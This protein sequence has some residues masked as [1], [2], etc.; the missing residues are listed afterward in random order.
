[1]DFTDDMFLETVNA[2]ADLIK[3]RQDVRAAKDGEVMVAATIES[4]V[5]VVQEAGEGK[6]QIT[7]ERSYPPPFAMKQKKD[8]T[9]S[10]PAGIQLF[11]TVNDVT[12]VEGQT[13]RLPDGKFQIL[14]KCNYFEEA[15]KWLSARYQQAWSQEYPRNHPL[16]ESMN[17]IR[18]YIDKD[19]ILTSHKWRTVSVGD[20]YKF[21]VSGKEEK[22]KEETNLFR[23]MVPGRKNVPYIQPGATVRFYKV[24]AE[25]WIALREENNNNSSATTDAEASAVADGDTH[26]K[27]NLGKSVVEYFALACKGGSVA[28]EDYDPLLEYTE[29]LHVSKN[30]DAHNLIPVRQFEQNQSAM[31][32]TAYFYVDRQYITKWSPDTVHENRPGVAVVRELTDVKDFLH[33]YQGQKSV[34]CSLRF[35]VFQWNGKPN[36]NERYIVKVMCKKESPMWRKFGITNMDAYAYIMAANPQ[37]PLHVTAN[38]WPSAVLSHESNKPEVMNDK[39]ELENIRG[40]YVYM[41]SDVTPDYLRYFKQNG[42]RLSLDYVKREFADWE[43]TNKRTGVVTITLKPLDP[44]KANPL[45]ERGIT[46]NVLALGNGFQTE[47][48]AAADGTVGINHAYDGP[49][50]ELFK[51]DH[52]FYFLQSKPVTKDE[53]EAAKAASTDGTMD[54][55]LDELKQKYKVFYWIY[56]VRRD[57]KLA[58]APAAAAVKQEQ[59]KR[60]RPE[61]NQV[62]AEDVSESKK[63]AEEAE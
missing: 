33:E 49:I 3:K 32:R 10:Y 58:A 39:P 46:S 41:A 26:A 61:D 45:N 16:H 14:V 1:M 36:K 54:H 59:K 27:T 47:E 44:T 43:S 15:S 37:V 42:A 6:K 20:R 28:T 22:E 48:Q 19:G 30:A 5:H 56:A 21:K 24:A 52:D 11:G 29:R 7:A 8:K 2:S 40:Y 60:E 4:F 34:G 9:G 18:E 38:V 55:F 23:K 31:P 51:G 13:R 17:T 35:S 53:L 50:T 57:A 25:A 62:E 12:L 63:I